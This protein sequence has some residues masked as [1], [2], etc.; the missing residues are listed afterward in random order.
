MNVYFHLV[1]LVEEWAYIDIQP[2]LAVQ[3]ISVV[4]VQLGPSEYFVAMV[5]CLDWGVD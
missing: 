2:V 1:K 4:V 5:A 3:A